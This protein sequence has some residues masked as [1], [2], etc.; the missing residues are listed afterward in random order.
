[1]HKRSEDAGSSPAGDGSGTSSD[2]PL[3]WT[4]Q[5]APSKSFF[6]LSNPVQSCVCRRVR[7]TGV[8][9]AQGKGWQHSAC[10]SPVR[11]KHKAHGLGL[12]DF[13][14]QFLKDGG[15]ELLQ[16]KQ[17]CF[18]LLM[19]LYFQCTLPPSNSTSEEEP[20]APGFRALQSTASGA[21]QKL[22]TD[23]QIQPPLARLKK[24]KLKLMS[25]LKE[26]P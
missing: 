26:T 11:D 25:Y 18:I 8:C 10:S 20:A 12:K 15:G 23:P 2:L 5:R 4:Q 19:A 13:K 7:D 6:H 24:K 14:K 9:R 1:M 21:D 3:K 17:F 16:F 22:G